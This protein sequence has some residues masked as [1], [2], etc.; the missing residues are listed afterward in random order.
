MNLLD[1]IPGGRVIQALMVAA[2]LAAITAGVMWFAHAQREIGRAEVRAEWNAEKLAQAE[3]GAKETQRRLER[4]GD[5]QREQAQELARYQR[6]AADAA[7]ARDG[8]RQLV[9]DLEAVVRRGGSVTATADERQAGA[10]AT[11]MLAD[12]SRGADEMAE[13]YAREADQSRFAGQLCERSYEALS[14][15]K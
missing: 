5:A 1:F 11:G 14:P 13:I 7:A 8:M 6:A 9:D 12:V 3:A 4:Q 2:A 10:A 15:P